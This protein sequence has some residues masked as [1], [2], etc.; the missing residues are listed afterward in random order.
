MNIKRRERTA[1]L[2]SLA[3]GVVPKIG[4]HHIQVG[5]KNELHALISD[6]MNIEDGGSSIRFI[7][8]RFGSGKSFFLNLVRTVAIERK[9]VVL[10]A[11]ITVD[12]RLHGSGGHA[13]ALYTELISNMS[14]RAKPEG[15]ALSGLIE[16]FVIDVHNELQGA[17]D[18]ESV[19]NA[20]KK[21][22][23]PLLDLAHG[24][25]FI[26]VLAK[27]VEG[28]SAGNDDLMNASTRW[29]RGEY[30]TKTEAR[31]DLNVRD[32]IEDHHLYDM[33]KLWAKFVRL[34]GYGG[35]FVNFDELVVLSERLNNKTA[36]VKNFEIIL[37]ILNDCLQGYV[38]GVGF[39]FAGTEEFLSDRRRGLF[40]Y[41][42]LATRLADNPFSAD[43]VI[44]THGP[45]IR[46]ES[47]S[48][49]DLFVLLGRIT[50]VHANGEPSRHLLKEE[51]ILRFLSFC[52]KR[53]GSEYFLTPRDAVQQFVG[54]LNVMEQNPEKDLTDFIKDDKSS[55]VIDK[56][57]AVEDKKN[58]TDHDGLTKFRLQ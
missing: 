28:F 12:R 53:L 51:G 17:T 10:Q 49:E 50:N 29:L 27:Y 48:R 6:L 16:R 2:Q 25:N 43:G 38:E 36:R 32:I 1:I 33:L 42:A 24:M 20:M 40:S 14:T 55:V 11:D 57:Q 8:G 56:E 4:L 39:C 47:L 44:D 23:Q 13:R 19:E 35:L 46:L 3:A 30:G 7:I 52:E 37:Q 58:T 54:L 31:Q 41:E 18:F 9:F 34:A 45:V 21:K 15:G 26:R 5:R 22:L